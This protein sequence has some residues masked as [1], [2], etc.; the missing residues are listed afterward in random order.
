MNPSDSKAAIAL[1]PQKRILVVGDA[2]ID[3]YVEGD[4][5]H[6]SAEAPVPIVRQRSV[7]F[8]LG[9]AGNVAANARALGGITTLV[10]IAGRDAHSKILRK[11]CERVSIR[12]RLIADSKRPTT[13]KLRIVSHAHQHQL[14]RL[15]SES[16]EPMSKETEKRLL[17][18]IRA[19]PPQDMVIVSDYAKGCITKNVIKLLKEKFGPER[20]V[21]DMKPQHAQF[22][23]GIYAITPNM[24]EVAALTGIHTTTDALAARATNILW[25][26]LSTTVIL[27]RAEHGVTLREKRRGTMHHF[28]SRPLSVKDVTGAGD[29]LIAALA[30]MLA[31]GA[32]LPQATEM[33]NLAAGI[34]VSQRGTVALSH[35]ELVEH[36]DAINVYLQ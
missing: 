16:A 13:T 26:R 19:L 20:I 25:K 10:A 11:L 36:L 23:K 18:A 29:T 31:A 4:V 7:R 14:A 15:D 35:K 22:Y 1:F 32:P 34:A 3:M 17:A 8:I 33:A 12:A 2:M 28:R 6:I 5:E 9:G 24:K 27:T 30:L 21:A